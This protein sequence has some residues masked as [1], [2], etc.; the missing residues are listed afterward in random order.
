MRGQWRRGRA[1]TQ[2][3]PGVVFGLAGHDARALAQGGK[4]RELVVKI[5]AQPRQ[6][7]Q[8]MCALLRQYVQEQQGGATIRPA[9]EREMKRGSARTEMRRTLSPCFCSQGTP[10]PSHL[11]ERPA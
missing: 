6:F 5:A 9:P 11:H 1:W 8:R 3:G 4:G 2:V 7:V 10:E